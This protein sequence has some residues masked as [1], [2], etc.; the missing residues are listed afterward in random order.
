[1]SLQD[2]FIYDLNRVLNIK[3]LCLLCHRAIHHREDE[4]KSKIIEKLYKD[5]RDGLEAIGIQTS[6]SDF[7]KTYGIK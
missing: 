7:E 2:K 5:S 1:M 3:G 6:L 4:G